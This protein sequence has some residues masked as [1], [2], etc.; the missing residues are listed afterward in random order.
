VSHRPIAAI[1]AFICLLVA[2]A[3]ASADVS[4]TNVAAHPTATGSTCDA[5]AP[6]D[7][8]AA[9]HRD[10]CV[11][12][13]VNAG[14]DDLRGLTLHLAPGLIGDPTAADECAPATFEAGGCPATSQVGSVATTAQSIVGD[15]DLT[16]QVFNL[17]PN[18]DEP[19]RLGIYILPLG[20]LATPIHIQSS[21][22]TRLD[23]YGLDSITRDDLPRQATLLGLIT[24]DITVTHM[25]LTLWGEDTL[26]RQFS[27]PFITVPTSCQPAT[28]RI[29]TRAWDG[30]G[31]GGSDT[32]T[33]T[34]CAGVPFTP[35]LEVGPKQVH[36][37]TPGEATA[38][39]K[40]PAAV[41]NNRVQA[42]VK[43]VELLLPQGLVLSPGL[44]NGLTD[45]TEAQFGL[46]E[47]R[48][49]ACP[50][51]SEIGDVEFVT[52]LIGTL[53]GKV[54]FGTPTPTAKL[55]NFVSVEDPRLRV[56]LIGDVTADPLTGQ[57]KN[58]FPDSP[59]VPFTEFR[60]R[61]K[62]GPNAV[63]SAPSTCGTYSAV[64]TMTPFSGGAA[65]SPSDTFDTI[66]CPQPAFTPTLGISS[67]S[68]L[69]GKDTALTVRID[70]P[71]ASPG[72][73]AR[74]SRCRPGSPAASER[75]PPA[76]SHRLARQRA[77]RPRAWAR[78]ASPWATAARR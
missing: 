31:S 9:S 35:S 1:A 52:P 50:A 22:R 49:P 65:A 20:G 58:I 37:D 2:P 72:S 6:V 56:K 43:S 53:T 26:T 51:S 69:A 29:E 70:R 28:T 33:P 40:V 57:V 23:D 42:N 67:S 17:Q 18:P 44:A 41:G 71:T 76:R 55:R 32:F 63:L 62:G 34:D 39:L 14:S 13:D 11:S 60:F 47:D 75:C 77:A 4:L 16:G 59:Q 5:S 45:C 68:T 46:K 25:A 78:R 64:A 61:Y 36:S 73:C 3:A 10:L 7:A 38:T 30:T 27:K 54:Y 15:L 48:A 21:I 24:S 74:R 66:D 12:F 8:P 19:A